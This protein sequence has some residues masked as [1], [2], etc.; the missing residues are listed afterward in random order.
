MWVVIAALAALGS[1][2]VG[3]VAI[4]AAR[5]WNKAGAQRDKKVAGALDEIA[6]D[7]DHLRALTEG[8]VEDSRRR[9]QEN[10]PRPRLVALAGHKETSELAVQLG[11]PRHV[12]ID[13]VLRAALQSANENGPRLP[14]RRTGLI[15]LSGFG[16]ANAYD[17]EKY[18]EELKEYE[19]RLRG[20]LEKLSSYESD[21]G[22]LVV[23]H[24]RIHND[25][26]VPLENA[27]LVVR[28]PDGLQARGH[29]D[30]S[31]ELN[32]VPRWRSPLALVPLHFDLA[33]RLAGTY[34][35]Y[36]LVSDFRSLTTPP[37]AEWAAGDIQH[38]E[39][40]DTPSLILAS[41]RTG[42]FT[43]SWEIHGDNLAEPSKGQTEL[44]VRPPS[45]PETVL[46]TL[47]LVGLDGEEDD[48]NV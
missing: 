31:P 43:L 38:G 9:A 7:I 29:I 6:E 3:I 14:P 34:S 30:K 37:R 2:L 12:D 4:D 18:N 40:R 15:A 27:R 20:Q 39:Q 26:S 42:E 28:V 23:L 25:G 44:A 17:I 24:F 10:I 8:V 48:D 47:A 33:D 35:P 1:V 11:A 32:K 16:Y 36:L 5:R 46:N 21:I 22:R 45:E 13:V 19:Q 41:D